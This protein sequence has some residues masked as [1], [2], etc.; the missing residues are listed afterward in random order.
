MGSMA[1]ILAAAPAATPGFNAAG[2]LVRVILSLAGI[3]AMILVV[4][5]L[6]RRMQ[7]RPG[8]GGRRIRCVESFAVGTRDRLL[9]LDADGKRLL[10]GMGPAGM[11]TLHVYEGAAPEDDDR[12]QVS[13]PAKPVFADMLARLRPRT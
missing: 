3:I 2:E 5:W 4:G 10:I 13:G 7:R 12:S 1:L 9:L 11:R 8:G 6:T